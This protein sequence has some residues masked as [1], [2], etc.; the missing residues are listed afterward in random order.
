MLPPMLNELSRLERCRCGAIVE[1]LP[2]SEGDEVRL[3]AGRWPWPDLPDGARFVVVDSV[4]HAGVGAGRPD[5]LARLPHEHACPRVVRRRPADDLVG[6]VWAHHLD[7]SKPR[8]YDERAAVWASRRH[9]GISTAQIAGDA[10]VTHQ[11]VSRVTKP[12]G[13]FPRPGSPTTKSVEQWIVDR[14][15]GLS[16]LAIA[17]RDQ[18]PV[19][20]VRDA[21]RHAG[22]FTRRV[23]RP[24]ELGITEIAQLLGV[25]HPTVYR[26]RRLGRLPEPIP[27]RSGLESWSREEVERWADAT[28]VE[29]DQCEARPMDLLR[30]TAMK[31]RGTA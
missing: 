9:E 11:W 20:R 29:C 17:S 22:P 14:R 31:H 23:H 26:W 5:Q 8:P 24:G 15:R 6:A 3:E 27:G 16:A 12:W 4:A 21:T 7:H 18:V 19:H 10:G 1:I 13:P 30:H 28:L 25:G 2:T